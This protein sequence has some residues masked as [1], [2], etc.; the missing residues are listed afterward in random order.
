MYYTRNLDAFV[1][2]L[3]REFNIPYAITNTKFHEYILDNR[4]FIK[5]R[6]IKISYYRLY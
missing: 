6:K 4:K 3:K 5:N 1:P 2:I